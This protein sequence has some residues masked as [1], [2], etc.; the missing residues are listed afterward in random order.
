M[1][2][3]YKRLGSSRFL[4]IGLLKNGKMLSLFE[5]QSFGSL[6]GISGG[7]TR[8]ALKRLVSDGIVER[9]NLDKTII[10][11]MKNNPGRKVNAYRLREGAFCYLTMLYLSA[12][13]ML[14]P[15]RHYSTCKETDKC[16]LMGEISLM[17]GITAKNV[18]R[19]YPK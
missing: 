1:S 16:K 2:E 5:I 8:I 14:V 4:I 19:L 11:K 13:T 17:F 12:P 9:I 18:I 3:A 15:C 7:T 6:K 10:K